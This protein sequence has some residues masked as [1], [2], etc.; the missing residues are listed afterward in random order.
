[1]KATTVSQLSE[2]LT[3]LLLQTGNV[4]GRCWLLVEG[5]NDVPRCGKVEITAD[6]VFPPSLY[7][8]LHHLVYHLV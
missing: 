6:L 5:M 2:S 8:G 4:L 1:M 7:H 3:A